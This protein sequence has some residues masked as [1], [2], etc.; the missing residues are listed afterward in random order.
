MQNLPNETLI[1]IFNNLDPC[2]LIKMKTV[3]TRFGAVARH[4]KSWEKLFI[5]QGYL[6][7]KVSSVDILLDITKQKKIL[8]WLISRVTV[9]RL[10]NMSTKQVT[11]TMENIIQEREEE[12]EL[13]TS[14]QI[15][16]IGD[17][18]NQQKILR[19][20]DLDM[21]GVNLKGVN[22]KWET[23]AEGMTLIKKVRLP[24][25]GNTNKQIN[26]L[27][28]KIV[29][30]ESMIL[31]NL[32]MEGINLKDVNTSTLVAAIAK[33]RR[34]DISQTKLTSEQVDEITKGIIAKEALILEHLSMTD[35]NLSAAEPE[36]LARAIV[37][38]KTT[39]IT[40]TKMTIKQLDTLS[41][42]VTQQEDRKLKGIKMWQIDMREVN[43]RKLADMMLK[44]DTVDLRE[45]YMTE[46]QQ[47]EILE[48]F[49]KE[50]HLPRVFMDVKG[51][52][53]IIQIGNRK[54]NIRMDKLAR[55]MNRNRNNEAREIYN[56]DELFNMEI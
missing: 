25:S 6:W 8:P 12:T 53:G 42:R 9:A 49:F 44:L 16:G 21:K 14:R 45:N 18:G 20:E 17:K 7:G 34:V 54:I 50:E 56:G 13:K 28:K 1:K 32:D 3:N 24:N 48:R 47:R 46:D 19:L 35:I 23:L 52:G 10:W 22:I 5:Y 36:Q 2:D 27:T 30:K 31:Q 39:D 4:A 51:I 26:L 55:A 41:D 29:R 15:L 33:I 11:E 37:R 40:A 43:T 38:L